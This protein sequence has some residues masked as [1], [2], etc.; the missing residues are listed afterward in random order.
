MPKNK[1]KVSPVFSP[2][3]PFVC[4]FFVTHE[5]P[6]FVHKEFL[7]RDEPAPGLYILFVKEKNVEKRRSPGVTY[8]LLFFLSLLEGL[9]LWRIDAHAYDEPGTHYNPRNPES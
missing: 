8:F 7:S 4:V 9:A 1:G 2:L 3:P 6:R 5:I